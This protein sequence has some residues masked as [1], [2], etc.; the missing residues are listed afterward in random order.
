[1]PAVNLLVMSIGASFVVEMRVGLVVLWNVPILM[2]LLKSTFFFLRG[3]EEFFGGN[4]ILC[5][6]NFL[7]CTG[8]LL[9]QVKQFL[10]PHPHA[11]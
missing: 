10:S 11:L 8:I 2:L 3:G 5:T 7:I 9:T 6:T 4:K 1:M